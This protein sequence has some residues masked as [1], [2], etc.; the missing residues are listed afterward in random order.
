VPATSTTPSKAVGAIHIPTV[1]VPTNSELGLPTPLETAEAAYAL[2]QVKSTLELNYNV[3][4]YVS[5][6]GALECI[7]YA[8]TKYAVQIISH[9]KPRPFIGKRRGQVVAAFGNK[10]GFVIIYASA[11]KIGLPNVQTIKVRSSHFR[12]HDSDPYCKLSPA[13]L[14]DLK[15]PA[16]H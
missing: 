16:L 4:S 9:G 8:H 15:A 6:A 2:A 7:N 10:V 5:T 1:H 3:G 14:A 12:Y 13:G 11:G